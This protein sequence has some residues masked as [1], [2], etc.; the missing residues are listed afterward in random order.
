M[1][2][3]IRHRTEDMGVQIP[4][5]KFEFRCVQLFETKLSPKKTQGIRFRKKKMVFCALFLFFMCIIGP[6][7]TILL[8]KGPLHM[9][10]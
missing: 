5:R 3:T 1:N 7:S 6:G 4:D 2:Q 9:L 10:L 8:I